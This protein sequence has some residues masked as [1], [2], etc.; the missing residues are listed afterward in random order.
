M[1]EKIK[2]YLRYVRHMELTGFEEAGQIKIQ[3]TIVGIVGAGG[4]GCPVLTYLAGAGIGKIKIIDQDHVEISN[5]QRQFLYSPA[6]INKPK[7]EIAAE[8]MSQFNPS[9]SLEYMQER[10]N[11]DNI[12]KALGECDIIADCSDN[13]D[14]RYLLNKF[15]IKNNKVLI[16]GAVSSTNG[17][18]FTFK[19]GYPCYECLFPPL[20]QNSQAPACTEA[21]VLGSVV[22]TIGLLMVSEIIKE[23]VGFGESLAGS[24]VSLNALNTS[25]QKIGFA[26]NPACQTCA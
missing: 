24:F 22:G 13:F 10:L 7:A 19:K 8:R 21:P 11:P 2:N 1:Q 5:L 26:Q 17:Q 4:L 14:T 18:L 15:S 3:N 16:S 12:E 20:P 23:I 6:E 25:S 9:I